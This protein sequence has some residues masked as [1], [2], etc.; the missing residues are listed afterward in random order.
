MHTQLNAIGCSVTGF[1]ANA[2]SATDVQALRQ[3]LYAHRLLV[4]KNQVL[5]A[6]QYG[7]FAMAFASPAASPMATDRHPQHPLVSVCGDA[8]GEAGACW[9]S[10]TSFLRVPKV[11]TLLMP[12]HLPPGCGRA[13]L[14]IDMSAVWAALSDALRLRLEKAAL[15]HAPRMA[16]GKSSHPVRHPAVI[17]HPHTH[18]RILYA[19]RAFTTAIAGADARESAAL[20]TQLF[21]FSEQPRFVKEVPWCEGDIMIWDNRFLQ[22]RAGDASQG[23]AHAY[24]ISACDSYPL[25]ASQYASV[26]AA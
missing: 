14:F 6:R 22:H 21:A 13:T 23:T 2:P 25:C 3:L 11:I 20:L 5:D 17:T 1:D 26:H 9:H 19:N 24:G 10:D 12:R 16:P 15:L 7:N 8:E 18:E 4:L